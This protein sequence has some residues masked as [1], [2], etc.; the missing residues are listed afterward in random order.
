MKEKT[1]KFCRYLAGAAMVMSALGAVLG[2]DLGFDSLD[3]IAPVIFAISCLL[4]AG[5]LLN[6]N[7]TLLGVGCGVRAVYLVCYVILYI[8]WEIEFSYIL[9]ET[10]QAVGFVL[11]AVSLLQKK[12]IAS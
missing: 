3:M 11:L 7:V 12:R 10:I 2:N 9:K 6:S 4:M 8:K 1:L 5:A